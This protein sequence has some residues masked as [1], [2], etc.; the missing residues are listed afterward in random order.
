M[1]PRQSACIASFRSAYTTDL[2]DRIQLAQANPGSQGSLW[3]LRARRGACSCAADRASCATR[4][5]NG[6]NRGL[7]R[8]KDVDGCR[9]D[10]RPR[11][12]LRH[13]GPELCT[14]LARCCSQVGMPPTSPGSFRL[15]YKRRCP[16]QCLEAHAHGRRGLER[17]PMAAYVDSTRHVQSGSLNLFL[18]RRTRHRLEFEPKIHCAAASAR[19]ARDLRTRY[20][21]MDRHPPRQNGKRGKGVGVGTRIRRGWFG[22]RSS[23]SGLQ[24]AGRLPSR[25]RIVRVQTFGCGRC[26]SDARWPAGRARSWRQ[27]NVNHSD[28]GRVSVGCSSQPPY[29]PHILGAALDAREVET[30][31]VSLAWAWSGLG[32]AT[33]VKADGDTGGSYWTPWQGT[34]TRCHV[35]VARGGTRM[36]CF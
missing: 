2:Y 1:G 7:V 24:V 29:A 18:A 34:K 16:T 32:R 17:G 12:D 6:P 20:P 21:R 36:T 30:T 22:D 10:G 14:S 5:S 3:F 23:S 35:T 26:L 11:S 27:G 15:R 28:A 4:P 31:S 13:S 33:A 25:P 9:K 19:S 8:P